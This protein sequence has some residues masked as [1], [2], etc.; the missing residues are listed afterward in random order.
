M[1]H[2]YYAGLS[3]IIMCYIFCKKIAPL[4]GKSLDEECRNYED[5][6][7]AGR[8]ADIAG[9]E[10]SIEH[11]KKEQWRAEGQLLLV[12]AKQENVNLQLEAAYRE[13][14]ASVFN[15]VKRRLDYQVQVQHVDR[16]V[17]QK[18]LVTW[19]VGN[20]LKSITPDQEKENINKCLADLSTLAAKAN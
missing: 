19:V 12:D 3:I 13:R 7:N 9:N 11:E 8:K 6:W 15:E 5:S 17:K 18:H 20:V 16:R 10:E 4:I 14:L 1:E 2:E